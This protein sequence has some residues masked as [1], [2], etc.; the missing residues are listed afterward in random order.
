VSIIWNY[1][2]ISL[3][4]DLQTLPADQKRIYLIR[5]HRWQSFERVLPTRTYDRLLLVF[6]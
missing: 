6:G 2:L 1:G 4:F 5:S 3:S